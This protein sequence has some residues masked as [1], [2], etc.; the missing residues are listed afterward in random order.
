MRINEKPKPKPKT[1]LVSE[2]VLSLILTKKVAKSSLVIETAKILMTL[3]T[4]D[5]HR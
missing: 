5:L 4:S 3:I 1:S 2:R